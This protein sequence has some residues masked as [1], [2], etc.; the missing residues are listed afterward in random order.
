VSFLDRSAVSS[1]A[2]T[3]CFLYGLFGSAFVLFMMVGAAMG[4]CPIN[5]DGSGCE[6]DQ[7]IKFIMFPGS[8]VVFLVFGIFFARYVT[9]DKN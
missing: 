2:Q 5:E 7:L 3:G 4:D 6:H 1:R 9:R 8:L